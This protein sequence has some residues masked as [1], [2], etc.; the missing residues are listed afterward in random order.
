MSPRFVHAFT[1]PF[2]D[3]DAAGIVF[4]ARTYT[5]AHRAY[6]SYLRHIGLG[7][8]FS[9]DRFVCPFVH[10]EADHKNP[11][12]P[13]E[14]LDVEVWLEKLGTS[15]MTFKFTIFAGKTEK[16]EVRMVSVFV[17]PATF[18]KIPI[19]DDIRAALQP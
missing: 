8:F 19:P 11:M 15:S 9:S 5:Y 7:E 6:E 1:V 16:A 2:D 13:G 14:H 3:A 4:F 17:D 12:R 18:T 10:T